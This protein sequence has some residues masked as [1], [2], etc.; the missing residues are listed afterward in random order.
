MLSVEATHRLLSSFFTSDDVA[1]IRAAA[2][3]VVA[4]SSGRVQSSETV[5]LRTGKPER[6][7]LYCAKV[8]GPLEDLR[9]LCG[10]LSG[11]QRAGE[12]CEKCGVLC[13]ERRLRSE[14]WGHIE[15]PAP[16]LHPRLLPVVAARLGLQPAQALRV[17]QRRANLDPNRG[18]VLAKRGADGAYAFSDP[19]EQERGARGPAF[20]QRA[21]GPDGDLLVSTIPVTPPAWRDLSG[22]ETAAY[23]RVINRATRLARLLELNAPAIIVENEELLL[24]HVFDRLHV[25]M[26]AELAARVSSSQ[27]G[28][29][30]G[31]RAAA[32]LAAVQAQ[33]E[34][35]DRRAVYADYLS[36]V[37]DPR[38][39]FIALQLANAERPRMSPRESQLLRRHLREWIAPLE[40]LL[41]E[42]PVFRRGFISRCRTKRGAD[43]EPLV[44]HAIW[45]TVEHLETDEPRLIT[46]PS[47][48]SLRS[49]GVSFSTLRRLCEAGRRLPRIE[50][51]VV[52]LSGCPPQLHAVVTG[53]DLLPSLREL[54][55]IHKTIGG[56]QDWSWLSGTRWLA[57]VRAMTIV[58]DLER[59]GA[60]TLRPWAALLTAPSKLEQV[61]VSIGMKH[62]VYELRRADRG[63]EL[64]ITLSASLIER[65]LLA[66]DRHYF[67]NGLVQACQGIDQPIVRLSVA[68]PDSWPHDS[69]RPSWSYLAPLVSWLEGV[70]AQYPGAELPAPFPAD[71]TGSAAEDPAAP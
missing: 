28:T 65:A 56:S 44:G 8:F 38:G 7:G 6:G 10:F 3:Q 22:A 17:L 15:S 58:S 51:A 61:T 14:R 20:L 32:L 47:M 52:R 45:A 27:R 34:A 57:E 13:G 59:H 67:T 30:R 53:S 4:S 48:T 41:E 25:T 2:A 9:C 11:A 40:G 26:R 63:V 5:Y 54:T 70:R 35:E 29:G 24:Q 66:Q 36:E 43:L 39:E 68:V 42:R 31:P 64:S 12:T 50:A 21:L 33:P 19:A 71:E 37:G 46:H 16:L 62:F 69:S 18:V 60:A 1:E 49:L 55:L 23:R